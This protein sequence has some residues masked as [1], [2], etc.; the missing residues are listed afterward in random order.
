MLLAKVRLQDGNKSVDGLYAI[1]WTPERFRRVFRFPNFTETDVMVEGSIY[2]Q[3]STN[4]MPLLIYELDGLIDF[5]SAIKPDP[6]A[7]SRKIDKTTA[8]L[9]C[10]SLLRDITEKK[11]CLASDTSLPMSIDRNQ[12]AV[13]LEALRE[14]FE[15]ADYQPFGTKQFPRTLNFH[16]WNSRS[17]QVQ[18]DKLVKV[19]S[20]PPDEFVPP[21]GS[22]RMHFCDNPK[23]TGETRPFTGNAIPVGLTDTEVAM[24]FQVSPLGAVR[25]AEVVYS[26]NPLKNKEIL[27]WF[28]GTHFPVKSCAGQPIA[29]ET[30]VTLVSG[31]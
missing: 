1:A 3:R 20:F 31:H 8:N 29:Y 18:I 22:T 13:G 30:I 24:Y 21:A 23:T 7:R 9:K 27:N 19:E 26:T 11:I 5:I 12:D 17:I 4:A 10:V 14:R 2:R 6:E 15:F 25:D 28:V 16:G